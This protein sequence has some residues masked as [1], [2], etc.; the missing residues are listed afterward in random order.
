MTV[1]DGSMFPDN[2]CFGCS[3]S[4]PHGL[5][6]SFTQEGDEVVT[7]LT[8]NEQQQGPPGIMH[9]G[10][11]MTLADEIGAWAIIAA[12]G[13]FGFTTDLQCKL[14]APVRVGVE[15]VGRGRIL[16]NRS[17]IIDT[18][19]TISQNDNVCAEATLRFAVLDKGAAEKMLGRALPP[20]WAG[21]AR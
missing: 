6:L 3:P 7:R 12:T 14:R 16:K 20:A 11:V 10:L 9:G 5:H 21:L 19:V 17:R 4:H 18:A 2:P 1:L 13:K 8:P 15:L